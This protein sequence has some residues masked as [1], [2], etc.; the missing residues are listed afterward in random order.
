MPF[1]FSRRFAK[2]QISVA[3]ELVIERGSAFRDAAG[4]LQ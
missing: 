3:G 2:L 1:Y 4:W